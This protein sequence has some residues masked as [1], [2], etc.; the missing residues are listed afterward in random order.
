MKRIYDTSTINWN[1]IA[2][3]DEVTLIGDSLDTVKRIRTTVKRQAGELLIGLRW[4][5]PE[6]VTYYLEREGTIGL[7]RDEEF[8]HVTFM[9]T[10][11]ITKD[12][13]IKDDFPGQSTERANLNTTTLY[14]VAN[15]GR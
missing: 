10:R 9:V 6:P 8:W 11:R 13:Q 15:E 1:D 12:W 2:V 3:G 4:G 14:D 5:R 7:W